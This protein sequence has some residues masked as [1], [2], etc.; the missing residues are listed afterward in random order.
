MFKPICKAIV[1]ATL[2]FLGLAAALVGLNRTPLVAAVSKEHVSPFRLEDIP[3]DGRAAYT[4][5]RQICAFGPRP[6][7]SAGMAAQ[8]RFV[9][10][11]FRR[12][13]HGSAS[14]SSALPI[15]WTA[16]TCPWPT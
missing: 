2:L 16:P 5:L 13:A 15:R 14:R 3:F 7:G 4:Y 6:S 12:S 8:Q 11:H 1:V 9:A 10:D